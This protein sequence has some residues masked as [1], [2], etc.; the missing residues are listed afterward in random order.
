MMKS[1]AR[2]RTRVRSPIRWRAES[3][4]PP[5]RLAAAAGFGSCIR[6]AI[7]WRSAPGPLAPR[8]G[9]TCGGVPGQNRALWVSDEANCNLARATSNSLTAAARYNGLLA[10][11]EGNVLPQVRRLDNL[12]IFRPGTHLPEPMPL[13]APIRTVA[14]ECY[15]LAGDGGTGEEATAEAEAATPPP[16]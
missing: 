7:E 12:G 8:C 14:A 2:C 5:M 13:D 11:L 15:P 10:S 16:D 1:F 3:G 4:P 6:P 9:C